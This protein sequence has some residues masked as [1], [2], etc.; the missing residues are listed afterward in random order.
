[1]SSPPLIHTTPATTPLPC[2]PKKWHASL[3]L[4]TLVSVL[5]RTLLNPGLS[6]L[7]V[8]SLRAQVTP[9]SDPVFIGSVAYAVLLTAL[10][11]LKVVNQRVAHGI[12][13]AVDFAS[14]VVVVTGG[15]SGLGLAIT[16]MY[17]MRGASVAVLDVAVLDDERYEEVFGAQGVGEGV[18]YY[19]CDVG[20]RKVVEDTRGKIEDE[21]CYAK[22]CLS[23]CLGSFLL[24]PEPHPV[25]DADYPNQLRCS[26]HKRSP[27]PQPER[28]RI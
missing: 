27:P 4:D 2:H 26:T 24:T 18:K 7:L 8:L 1:M 22:Y 20:D 14:E 5:Y 10:F 21:V 17:A 23:Y 11:V 13:R 19:R 25:G 3:T 6:W 16:Q 15:A 12:P 28:R 9:T